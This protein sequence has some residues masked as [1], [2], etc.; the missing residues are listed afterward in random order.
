MNRHL[1]QSY[2]DSIASRKVEKSERELKNK[3]EAIAYVNPIL[4]E[5]FGKERI[6]KERPYDI[7]L[8]DGFWFIK[9]TLKKRRIGGTFIVL[10]DCQDKADIY[11]THTK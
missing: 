2:R 9:G 8:I 10:V 7:Y 11:I 5:K 6:K 1:N 3:K 4:Y